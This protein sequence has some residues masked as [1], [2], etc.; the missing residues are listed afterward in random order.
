MR[1]FS[2]RNIVMQSLFLALVLAAGLA[3][4][5]A[6]QTTS[7][8]ISGTVVDIQ[9]AAVPN[10]TVTANEDEKKYT[11]TTKSDGEGRFVFPQVAPGT[12]RITVQAPGFKEREQRNVVVNANDRIALGD[13]MAEVGAVTEHVEVSA[14]GALLQ[15]ESADRESA[16]VNKQILNV[17]NNSRSPLDLVKAVPGVVSTINLATAGPGGLASISANGARQNSNQAMIN[18][19]GN[20]DTGSNGS[21][22]VTVSIDSV[23]EFK[24]L[25]GVYQ[26]EYGRAMGAQI[27]IVTKSGSSDLHGSGYFYHRNDSLNANNWLNNRNGTPRNLFRFNDFGY[28]L[29][30][31]VVIPKIVNGRQKLFFFVSEEFQRQLQPVATKFVTTPTTAERG[32]D[33]SN[34]VDLNG[35]KIII[36]DPTTSGCTG[37]PCYNGHLPFPNNQIPSAR[38][39]GP[40]VALL[41]LLPT[42]NVS[43][44]CSLLGPGASGCVKGYD[45]QSQFSTQYPRREDLV[46]MDYNITSNQRLFGHFIYNSNT[47]QG[48]EPGPFVFGSNMPIDNIFYANPGHGWAVGHSWTLSPTMTNELNVGSTFNAIRIDTSGTKYTRTA[49]GVTLPLLYPSADQEDLVPQVSF[50]GSHIGN[51]PTFGTADAPFVNHNTTFDLTDNVAKIWGKH[52]LKFGMYLDRSW[53]DQTSFGDFNGS[54]NFNDNSANPYDTNFGFSNA[55][56]GVYNSMD[57]AANMINGQY[58]YWQLEFYAQDTFK[59]TPR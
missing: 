53:K 5:A 39:Y 23:E 47:Y 9:H 42:P 52:A 24:I 27:N 18:G 45:Y 41:K 58:R 37:S 56:L 17:A 34:S 43:N 4:P 29:G 16:L 38:L 44:S 21:L 32:G 22:N 30:G 13:M 6:A 51:N 2:H 50:S 55:A 35:S 57:Q 12:Y 15:T 31:P 28:T 11:L 7:G 36:Y 46:R 49:S 54:Y 8:Y 48:L 40:G 10:A 3:V 20:T 33:F 1:L 59:V 19:I 25:T 26:A 14:L